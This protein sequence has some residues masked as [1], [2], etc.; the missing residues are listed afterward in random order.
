[1]HPYSFGL[2]AWH[3]PESV[4]SSPA[5][6]Q[7]KPNQHLDMNSALDF[8]NLAQAER[9]CAPMRYLSHPGRS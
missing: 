7:P 4:T 1:M 9:V 3:N 2:V 5:Q 6:A 8:S